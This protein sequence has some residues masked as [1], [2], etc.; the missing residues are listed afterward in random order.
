MFTDDAW[1]DRRRLHIK[2][3]EQTARMLVLFKLQP[4]VARPPN[5]KSRLGEISD[6]MHH[7]AVKEQIGELSSSRTPEV[8][9]K[10][11]ALS[12]EEFSFSFF[13]IH[14]VITLD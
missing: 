6:K 5:P 8:T 9:L 13:S 3:Y 12:L 14:T 2:L 4:P 7:G 11:S 10:V 1:R